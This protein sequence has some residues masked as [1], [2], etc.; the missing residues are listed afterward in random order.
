[1]IT[2]M[3]FFCLFSTLFVVG[4]FAQPKIQVLPGTQ[5]EY[6]D[7]Y[8]GKKVEKIVTIKNVGT[9][10]LH[11]SNVRA[12][13]G[14]TATMLT[15]NTLAP[16]DSGKLQITFNTDNQNGKVSKQVYVSSNDS[17]NPK[18][19][20][21]FSANVLKVLNL[22]PSF[23]AFNNS[24]VDSTYT[25]TI[26]IMNPSS[27]EAIKILSV[28]TK[29]DQIKVSLMKNQLMPGEQT[30]LQAVFHPTRPGT[31]QGVIEM[32]T[33]NQMQPKIEVKFNAWVNRK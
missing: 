19:T 7:I 8:Q 4:L 31:Y 9:D 17:T 15:Q 29:F 6:G 14:C 25:K 26:T 1:M 22:T 32:L 12:Q 21:T 5:L 23:F 10:T 28:D 24:K 3:F 16:N 20:I 27:K 2:K 33:D 18:L 11:I 30:E 13:C